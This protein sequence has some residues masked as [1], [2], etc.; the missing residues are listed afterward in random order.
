MSLIIN[1]LT[2]IIL[3]NY[4]LDLPRFPI[5]AKLVEVPDVTRGSLRQL[6]MWVF[7]MHL[8]EGCDALRSARVARLAF[9]CQLSQIWHKKKITCWHFSLKCQQEISIANQFKICQIWESWHKKRQPGNPALSPHAAW[10]TSKT[11]L[12]RQHNTKTLDIHQ[13][14][15]NKIKLQKTSGICKYSLSIFFFKW[16]QFTKFP[17]E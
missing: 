16:L 3:L 9:L 5:S 8:L 10:G 14:I 15:F 1:K 6:N 12:T 13:I 7:W 11:P 2:F 4:F 17:L